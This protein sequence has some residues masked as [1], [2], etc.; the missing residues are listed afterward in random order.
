M[1]EART[2]AALYEVRRPRVPGRCA[3]PG[4]AI[5]ALLVGAGLGL[6][7]LAA[8]RAA[9]QELRGQLVDLETD[10]PVA[11]GLI[12]LLTPDSTRIGTAVSDPDGRW[13]LEVPEPGT[14]LVAAEAMGYQSWVAGP[15]QLGSDGDLNSV[16]HLQPDPIVL[17][18]V[19]VRARAARRYLDYAGFFDRQRSN[20]GHFMAPGDIER[21]Q[22]G[23]VTE[24]LTH[25]PGVRRLSPAGGSVGPMQ[26]QLRG[27]NL[28]QGG[29]CRPRVFVDGLIYN[30]GDSRPVEFDEEQ[31]TEFEEDIERRLDQALSLDDIGHPSTILA[32]EIYRSASQVP[33]RFGGTS[34]Q[35]LCGVIVVW[36]RTGRSSGGGVDGRP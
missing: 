35:T 21:R 13:T 3:R 6:S 12:A 31:A 5:R 25:V 23:T 32:I 26:I 10:Q 33:V 14:Y 24:L 19:E 27:S 4:P 15:V 30:Y 20:F 11:L 29:T 7:M 9:G 18:E 8:P 2:N 1:S 28:S 22:A 17:D 16:F 34:R 36:T